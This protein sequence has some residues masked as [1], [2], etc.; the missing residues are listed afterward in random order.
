[1]TRLTRKK[2]FQQF[3]DAG[4]ISTPT[5]DVYFKRVHVGIFLK[6]EMD[7]AMKRFKK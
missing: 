2:V 7:K 1:M 4:S 3:L 5:L 6:D